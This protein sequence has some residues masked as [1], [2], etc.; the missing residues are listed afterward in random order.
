MEVFEHRADKDDAAGGAGE[1]TGGKTAFAAACQLRY[2]SPNLPDMAL[3]RFA[4]WTTVFLLST[5]AFTVLFERGPFD[6]FNNAKKE[7]E[8]LQNLFVK[9]VERRADESHKVLP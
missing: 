5:F 9:K 4:F 1:V 6:Y 8:A 7:A 3:L 2:T